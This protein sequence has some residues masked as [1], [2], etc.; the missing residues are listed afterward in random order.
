MLLEIRYKKALII[1]AGIVIQ[2]LVRKSE[3]SGREIAVFK[4][5]Q[6]QPGKEITTGIKFLK[7]IL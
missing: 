6:K 2:H 5:Y 1:A 7:R 4:Q 3:K